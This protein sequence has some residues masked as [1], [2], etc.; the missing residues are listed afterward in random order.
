MDA[1]WTD[2]ERKKT[3]KI[4]LNDDSLH[5]EKIRKALEQNNGFCPCAI[6]RSDDTKC[7][8]RE[9]REQKSGMCHCGLYVKEEEQ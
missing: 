9:F 1:A 8:C 3:M 2:N 7:M 4:K 5:V 6:E